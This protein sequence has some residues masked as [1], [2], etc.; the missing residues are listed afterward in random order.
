M[1]ERTATV[2]T[3]ADKDAERFGLPSTWREDGYDTPEYMVSADSIYHV[4]GDDDRLTGEF[5]CVWPSCS[6]RHRGLR[7]IFRHVHDPANHGRDSD[8]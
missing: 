4:R 3:W 6:F 1:E 8:G 2:S 5:K 7:T